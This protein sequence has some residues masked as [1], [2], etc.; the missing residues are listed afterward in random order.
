[1]LNTLHHDQAALN[2]KK[3]N[4]KINNP[5]LKQYLI[6]LGE[7][8]RMLLFKKLMPATVVVLSAIS[9]FTSA[10]EMEIT[11]INKVISENSKLHTYSG[12]VRIAFT[13]DNLSTKSS[14]A[15]FQK[16]KTVMEGDVEIIFSN[17]I[18]KTQRVTFIPSQ[19]GLVAEMDKVTFTYK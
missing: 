17:A 8:I 1:M 7:G 18:A 3:I 16:G 5:L 11:A 19:Q 13:H 10:N 2:T 15:S 12:N 9:S 6:N 4:I 14:R